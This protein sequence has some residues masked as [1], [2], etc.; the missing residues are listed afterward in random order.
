[1]N[2]YSTALAFLAGIAVGS[3]VTWYLLKE[4]Y[5]ALA[6]EEIDS[7]KEVFK[8][9]QAD[10]E[11]ALKP[12]TNEDKS[13]LRAVI[14]DQDIVKQ[15]RTLLEEEGYAEHSEDM[16]KNSISEK[17]Y[18]ITPVQFGDHEEYDLITLTYYSNGVLTYENNEVIE[19]V[20]DTVGIDSLNHFG[21]Y[22]D[23]SVFV[24]NDIRR[25]DYEILFDRDQYREIFD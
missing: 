5:R 6:Q 2:R 15:L 9:R 8:K 1:M 13:G 17:P 19:D 23:D 7:V 4:K 20:D 10:S 25:C 22:E 24:R 14:S 21:E 11:E 3:V 16:N 12:A 18:V